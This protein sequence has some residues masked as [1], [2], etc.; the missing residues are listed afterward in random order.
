MKLLD[1]SDTRDGAA[2]SSCVNDGSKGKDPHVYHFV[3]VN[4]TSVHKLVARFICCWS[5]GWVQWVY[6][7]FLNEN[8]WLLLLEIG[9][10][11]S[12]KNELSIKFASRT[13]KTMS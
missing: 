7:S 1:L 3:S 8:S 11:E 6:Q 2:F 12:G 4:W 13:T 5:S 10:D 9:V